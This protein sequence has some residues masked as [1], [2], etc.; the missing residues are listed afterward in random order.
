M[1]RYVFGQERAGTSKHHPHRW[2]KRDPEGLASEG[3]AHAKGQA[4]AY[5]PDFLS[6]RRQEHVRDAIMSEDN[7]EEHE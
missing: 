5:R 7:A 4:A 3:K 1:Y 6:G 2:D